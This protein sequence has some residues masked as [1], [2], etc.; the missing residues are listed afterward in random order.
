M[1][2]DS[3][4]EDENVVKDIDPYQIINKKTAEASQK[5]KRELKEAQSAAKKQLLADKA[6]KEKKEEEEAAKKPENKGRNNRNREPNAN[7]S[8]R[9]GKR[10]QQ[11][12]GQAGGE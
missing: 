7:R 10:N 8:R 4:S 9:V 6:T 12:D 11:D 2:S 5:A 1:D 3:E